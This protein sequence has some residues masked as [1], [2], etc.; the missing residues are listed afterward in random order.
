[1][2]KLIFL[3]FLYSSIYGQM[4]NNGYL[5]YTRASSQYD[6][7]AT[8]DN[9]IFDFAS[10][11]YTIALWFRPDDISAAHGFVDLWQSVDRCYLY[12]PGTAGL[13]RAQMR[14]DL[15]GT[16]DYDVTLWTDGTDDFTAGKWHFVLFTGQYGSINDTMKI[17]VKD[18]DGA[19]HAA[20][21]EAIDGSGHTDITWSADSKFGKGLGETYANGGLDEIIFIDAYT[22]S[23]TFLTY[24]NNGKP[25][26]YDANGVTY[27]E[28]FRH[29]TDESTQTTG[30]NS[31]VRLY[32]PAAPSWT[33]TAGESIFIGGED[34]YKGYKKGYKEG[35]KK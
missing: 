15:T 25:Y 11:A 28:W 29:E 17:F 22:D 3:I 1:M 10:G 32:A 27:K 18:T 21:N 9:A 19:I 12:V 6:S 4:Q 30:E 23:L 24:W 31:T 26:D 16:P 13:N 7:V 34:G 35:Y 20:K 33:S 2:K 8:A 14:V 5:Q